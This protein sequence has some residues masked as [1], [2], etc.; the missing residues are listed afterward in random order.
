MK[1]WQERKK[2][3][4]KSEWEGGDGVAEKKNPSINQN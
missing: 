1:S 3:G 4:E 2:N